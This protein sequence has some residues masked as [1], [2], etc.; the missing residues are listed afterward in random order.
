MLEI[1]IKI[2]DGQ[3]PLSSLGKAARALSGKKSPEDC[4]CG[5]YEHRK[6]CEEGSECE[7]CNRYC[8]CDDCIECSGPKDGPSLGATAKKLSMKKD[9]M[10]LFD[11]RKKDLSNEYEVQQ[12]TGERQK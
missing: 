9:P 10:G 6:E 4:S 3:K 11:L 8:D 7:E 12:T 5:H 2:E 1:S